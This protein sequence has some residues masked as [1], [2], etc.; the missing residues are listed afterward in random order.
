MQTTSSKTWIVA[1]RCT[2]RSLRPTPTKLRFRL[3]ART[4]PDLP[5]RR[6]STRI[7]PSMKMYQEILTPINLKL[8]QKSN[9]TTL[10]SHHQ[11]FTN[12]RMLMPSATWP[13]HLIS[14]TPLRS[15]S[16]KTAILTQGLGRRCHY[17]GQVK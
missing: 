8:S 2:K 11:V 4:V 16:L 6:S 7:S 14:K 3:R 10:L 12:Q 1:S 17:R 5:R 15:R 9:F 13:K